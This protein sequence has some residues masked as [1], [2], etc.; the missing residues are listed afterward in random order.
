MKLLL[1]F[2]LTTVHASS[3][4]TVD[5]TLC[6]SLLVG[7]AI[8]CSKNPN[9]GDVL[10]FDSASN[11]WV[12]RN[13]GG[14]SY[15]GT[16]DASGGLLPVGSPFTGDYYLISVAGTISGTSYIVGDW[17]TYTEDEW[18]K[19]SNSQNV[20]SV[21]GR[22]GAI[23]ARSGDYS[24]DHFSDVDVTVTPPAL[25]YILQYQASGKW[26]PAPS[27][28][29]ATPNGSAG[30]HLTGTYPAP[31]LTATGV[32]PG[33]YHSVTVNAS[34]RITNGTNP[35][36][37]A[38]Y[39]ITDTIVGAVTGTLPVVVGGTVSLPSVSMSQSTSSVNGWLSSIDWNT[40]NSKQSALSAGPVINGI[41]YPNSTSE[42]LIAPLAP[43]AL[44]D[45]VNKQ[46][47]ETQFASTN[48]LGNGSGDTYRTVGNIGIG[49]PSPAHQLTIG[50]GT[51][52]D[53]FFMFQGYGT[54]GIDGAT[55][56]S[57][58]S[59]KALIWYAKKA[60][61]RAGYAATDQFEDA[62]IGLYS[63]GTG[64]SSTGKGDYSFAGSYGSTAYG[65]ASTAL[66]ASATAGGD[67]STMLG[68]WGY[69][70]GSY[71]TALGYKPEA[72][73]DYSTVVCTDTCTA[74]GTYSSAFG[75]ATTAV[76]N[77]STVFGDSTE[78]S[79][80]NETVFGRENTAVAN[81]LF[82]L[83]NGNGGD[84]TALVILKSGEMGIGVEAPA[85][86]LQVAGNISPEAT[87]TRDIGTA[88]LKFK[89]VFAINT[90]IQTSDKRS[91]KDIK[92]LKQGVNFLLKLHPV[93]Y[94]WKDE[95]ETN[96]HY[97][98]LAQEV[99][100]AL[101]ESQHSVVLQDKDS[102]FFGMNYSELISP[103]I[104]AI[105]ELKAL[106]NNENEILKCKKERLSELKAMQKLTNE[107]L[108]QVS[109]DFRKEQRISSH[110]RQLIQ[111]VN[112]E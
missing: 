7:K 48:W 105:K 18:Q 62:N 107:R 89:D 97:G 43:S 31:S 92:E 12:F 82:T 4:F 95:I 101:K 15:K 28:A 72:I 55:I 39:G 70:L 22:T 91:K 38:G 16:H 73:G 1:L 9:D 13:A 54:V 58:G 68:Q 17:I 34:G 36:T 71:S 81:S 96:K 53:G 64:Y 59:E 56:S 47:A 21:F 85:V 33:T 88:S 20:L 37:L 98:F 102:G 30:G 104:L 24:L 2:F 83:G 108:A 74:Q 69:T 3:S 57:T 41:D 110:Y 40:F 93:S 5:F 50:D 106:I 10:S 51:G 87:G 100:A 79:N 46:Y 99:K 61:F 112:P 8:D 78:S 86:K 42:T 26:M 45:L 67:Y 109:E 23:K 94:Q 49:T 65:I 77:Y 111:K 84:A 80:A 103:I 29:T 60:A 14:L 19:I 35:T 32:T 66:G 6:E 76:E 25:G 44:T 27:S 11:K 63:A 75:G 52:N 90:I